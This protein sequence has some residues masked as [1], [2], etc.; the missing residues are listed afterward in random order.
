MAPQGRFGE[1]TFECMQE[2]PFGVGLSRPGMGLV[3]GTAS[4]FRWEIC[5]NL[6]VRHM[7]SL[8]QS[9]R[10]AHARFSVLALWLISPEPGTSLSYLS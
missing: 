4:S 3:S 9:E 7:N 2:D 5:L 8:K 10:I 1:H 6:F